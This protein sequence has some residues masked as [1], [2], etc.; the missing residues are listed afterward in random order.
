M[1]LFVAVLFPVVA[2]I[3]PMRSHAATQRSA[4]IAV[5]ATVVAGCSINTAKLR[6]RPEAALGAGHIICARSQP[7]SAIA[8]PPPTMRIT[9]DAQTGL[10]MLTI[11]F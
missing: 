3:V 1:R 9:R 6:A 5:S 7:A 8:A 4:Q 2:T 10:S 11:A